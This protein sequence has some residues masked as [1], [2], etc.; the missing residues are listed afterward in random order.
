MGEART[1]V[2]APVRQRVE[3][4]EVLRAVAIIAVVVIH[5]SISEWHQL[6][7]GGSRA[8]QLTWIGSALRF[9][10][11]VFF[12][13]SGVLFLAPEREV[14]MGSLFRKSIP[15]LLIPFACWSLCYALVGVYG[16]G[17]SRDSA[18]FAGDALTGH[19]HL[20]FLL[21]LTGLY[22][23]V[24][25]LRPVVRD[26]RVAWYFV[27]LAL[28][29]ASVLPLLEHLPV[30]G[31]VISEV[32]GDMRFDLVL[33]YSA[34]F[35]LGLLLDRADLSPAVLA[36]LAVGGIAGVVAT[37]IGTLLVSAHSG[38]PDE[39]FFDFVTPNVAVVAIAL[40][41]LARA[42]GRRFSLSPGWRRAVTL[43]GGYSFG[44]YLIHPLV[45]WAYRQ[46]GI[47]TEFAQPWLSVPV[48]TVLVLVPSLAAAM[49]IRRIPGVGRLL[50]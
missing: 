35:I 9:C 8:D 44:I 31:E 33:G 22:L 17:G 41:A 6:P 21:A 20:W 30:A 39:L 48:L 3:Y 32:L 26:R 28:P 23:A 11:P 38:E 18:E 34:F 15:R 25:I 37:G 10:V 27:A 49:L 42:W 46:F 2:S 7:P 12:M 16:P 40:F 1:S 5:A 19:F 13:V 14:A 45:Q 50:A 43:L 47:T 29:F 24:P 4:L 36:W